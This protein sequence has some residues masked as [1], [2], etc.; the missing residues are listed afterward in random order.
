MTAGPVAVLALAPAG[1]ALATGCPGGD[2]QELDEAE[3]DPS[4]DGDQQ[5]PSGD[6]DETGEADEG[7]CGNE[8]GPEP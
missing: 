3:A 6:A 1:L 5:A 2:G 7:A 8:T 4:S